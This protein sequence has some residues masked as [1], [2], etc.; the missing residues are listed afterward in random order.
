[1]G[2]TWYFKN[3]RLLIDT[4]LEVWRALAKNLVKIWLK[5]I[6]LDMWMLSP[7]IV[8]FNFNYKEVHLNAVL[9]HN[10]NKNIII[11]FL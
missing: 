7:Q 3:G 6:F 5:A 2:F 9:L 4:I 1:M 10:G 11:I 8:S